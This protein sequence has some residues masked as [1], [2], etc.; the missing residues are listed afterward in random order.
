MNT[1]ISVMAV[2]T[3][4]LIC[5]IPRWRGGEGGAAGERDK[6]NKILYQQQE[7]IITDQTIE[8]LVN[9]R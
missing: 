5:V 3:K 4:V 6:E 7:K 2:T 1:S 8:M 9:D